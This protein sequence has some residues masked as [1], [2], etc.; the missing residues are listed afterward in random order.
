MFN[1]KDYLSY[2]E[3]LYKIE[4]TMKK[5]T[6]ELLKLIKDKKSQKIIKKIHADEVRHSK[7]VKEMIKLI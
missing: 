4:L 1:K 2:F 3:Q 7:I 6:E 5:E